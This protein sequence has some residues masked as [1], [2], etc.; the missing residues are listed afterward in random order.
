MLNR[1]QIFLSAAATAAVAPFS[2]ALAQA[3]KA[4][5][6]TPHEKLNALFDTFMDENL[7][8][9]PEFA[10][11]L[12]V[13]KGDKAGERSRLSDN[14]AAGIARANALTESQQKRLAAFDRSG[15][16]GMDR[17]NYDIVLYGLTNQVEAARRFKFNG[18]GAGSPYGVSQ[19]SGGYV[20][21]PD[22]LDSQHP[23][24][25]KA[26]AD[27]YIARINGLAQVFDNETAGV[28]A[29]A[30]MGV[31]PPDFILDKTLTQLKGLR[32]Q[33]PDKIVLVQ[34]VVRRTK[35]KA[36]PG[37]W[38]AQASAIYTS[39]IQPAL[40]RQIALMTELRAK[41][42]HDAGVWKLPDGAAYYQAALKNWAT[43][44]QSPAEIHKIG[45]DLV[46][47]L[48]ARI[49]AI[50]QAQGLT[51]GTV[52]QRLRGMYK[53]PKFLY[54]DTDEG[55]EKLLADL[56][57][58]VKVVQAKLPAYFNTLPKAKLE[59]RRVPKYTEVGAPGGYYNN[60]SLDGSRPGAYYINLHSTADNPSWTLPTLTYHEGIPGHH[61]QL[62]IQQEADLPLI[63]KVS[64]FSA[65]IEGW[66]L[67]AEQ[68]ADEMGMY[69]T[70]PWG[71]I[72]YLHD[73][74]FRAVRLVVDTGLHSMR[75]ERERAI[76][77]FVD[78]L[79][80]TDDSATR[81]VERYCVWPGQACTYMLGKLDWLKNREKAKAALGD[82]FTLG[83]FHDTGLLS[84][85]M[86]LAVLDEVMDAWIASK[87]A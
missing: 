36:I 78:T 12:G 79:G 62:S 82:R 19:L 3:A 8:L 83:E 60:G 50:M 81:E 24:E 26:D 23:I 29:D 86:P 34:S 28:R 66:A 76:K 47:D 14:S 69:E 70:D 49:D 51:A 77:Y 56:N 18:G 4:V 73:A 22:F 41:A 68:M 87:K 20:N 45:L 13:D 61:M 17:I 1:R 67:Y 46:A 63:R 71:K 5:A 40:D 52:G 30:A 35:E 53:D 43:T 48:T 57:E 44:S 21:F 2:S 65:Y 31:I 58:K 59:I 25:N 72:G 37:D 11:S 84:G 54:P 39:K 9:S 74:M 10:T 15:L 75:W 33:G 38:E 6:G 80:D 27:A 32:G 16:Q 64:F 85:A 55:K 7:R 42:T